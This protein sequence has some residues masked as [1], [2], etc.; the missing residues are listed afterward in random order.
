MTRLASSNCRLFFS[1]ISFC[2]S[3]ISFCVWAAATLARRSAGR[4]A[5]TSRRVLAIGPP[6]RLRP[7]ST[8]PLPAALDYLLLLDFDCARGGRPTVLAGIGHVAEVG[9]D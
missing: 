8:P 4:A 7:Q 3:A 5:I 6:P 9:I 1:A 2:S